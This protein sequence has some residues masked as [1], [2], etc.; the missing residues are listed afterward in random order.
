VRYA[1]AVASVVLFAALLLAGCRKPPAAAE[2]DIAAAEPVAV[3]VATAETRPVETTI[4]AQ[5]TLTAGQGAS[6]RIAASVPGRLLT[7]TVREGDR[8]SAGQVV[9][10]IDNRPQAAAVGS[11]NAAAAAAE[12]QAHSADIGAG[13]AA[14]D[15]ANAVR[16]AQLAVSSATLDRENSLQAARSSL[17][18]AE[19]DLQKTKAGARPQEIA[20]AD[21][22]VKQAQASRDRAATEVERVKFLYD[23][24][25]DSKRQLDD[26]Q[27]ALTVA[28]STLEG[29][30]Q[31][32][33]LVRAG[34]R[35]E[36]LRAADIRVQQARQAVAQAQS[37]GDAK[38]AQAAAALR[39]AREA[40]LQVAVKR[41]DARALHQLAEA[42]R[43][44]LAAARS[45]AAFA[46][47]RAP[48]SGIVTKRNMNP[49][50]MADTTTQ[51]LE[52]AERGALNLVASVPAEDGLEIRAGMGAHISA[53]DVP[54]RTFTGRVLNVGQVD[55]TTN[56][57]AVRLSV[58]DARGA[59]RSGTFASAD[60]IVRTDPRAVVV[61]K[62]AIVSKEG[63][64]VLFL[65]GADNVA[66]QVEIAAGTERDGMVEVL[67]G[68]TAGTKVIRLGQYEIADGAKVKPVQP[69]AAGATAERPAAE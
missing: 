5:G 67:K 48:F 19:T 62:Q 35:P 59:L 24:G 22:A 11:A 29:A 54:N 31:Q 38:V 40:A 20:Q 30:R 6:A 65:V 1:P 25:I 55:P 53:A 15:Q 51:I 34:A 47:V 12:Q 33:S 16:L 32:A 28:D 58:S 49:G 42:K 17:Q 13:A 7:V 64:S 45:T 27:T 46:E 36:D 23:K 37:S 68:V 44:D 8:V 2:S 18:A 57:L 41:Q 10:T 66:H 56:L 21:Q 4:L 14:V 26:A 50:D 52:I 69:Q 63:K 60:I 9:A 61:P 43:A 39:Q 3:E